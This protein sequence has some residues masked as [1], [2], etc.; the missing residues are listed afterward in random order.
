MKE[1]EGDVAHKVC[2]LTRT[3]GA[4]S[5]LLLVAT[6]AGNVCAWAVKGFQVAQVAATFGTSKCVAYFAARTHTHTDTRTHIKWQHLR[7]T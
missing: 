3:L 6:E 2:A 7:P 5:R 1:R 4:L